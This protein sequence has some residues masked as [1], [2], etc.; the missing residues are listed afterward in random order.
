MYGSN[1]YATTLLLPRSVRPAVFVFYAFVR[2]ADELVDNP[3]QNDDVV[4]TLL[5]YENEWRTC[6]HARKYNEIFL[7]FRDVCLQ[8]NIDFALTEDFLAAMRQDTTT[9]RYESYTQLHDYMYGSAE[10]VGIIL[11]KLFGCQETDA[12]PYAKALGSA[13]Q[14]TNFL[15]DIKEDCEI[16]DRIYIPQEDLRQFAVSESELLNIPSSTKVQS[17]I[18]YELQRARALYK[19][20]SRGIPYLPHA[21]QPAVRA[22]SALYSEILNEIERQHYSVPSQKIRIGR[23]TKIRLALLYGYVKK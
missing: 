15:R 6:Y 7:A 13:M 23:L 5:N 3:Q 18:K 4:A 22:A 16:R 14:L 19:E 21:I 11:T 17:L 8:Y 2:L 9:L 20:A 12:I 1:Y 10:V